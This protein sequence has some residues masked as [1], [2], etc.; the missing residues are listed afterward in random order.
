M[1][2]ADYCLVVVATSAEVLPQLSWQPPEAH[3]EIFG[4]RLSYFNPCNYNQRPVILKEQAIGFFK[5]SPPFPE[6]PVCEVS[7]EQILALALF[8]LNPGQIYEEY[9][10]QGLDMLLKIAFDRYDL[11]TTPAQLPLRSLA[12]TA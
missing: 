3:K 2:Y 9:L 12:C 7:K 5:V 4:F 11:Q 6:K 1:M 10:D 8:P